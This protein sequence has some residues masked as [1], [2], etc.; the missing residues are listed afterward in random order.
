ME[1]LFSTTPTQKLYQLSTHADPNITS[2]SNKIT[3][4]GINPNKVLTKNLQPNL[5]SSKK[6]NFEGIPGGPTHN[7]PIKTFIMR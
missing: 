4:P 5:E 1:K 2:V 3:T 6:I 7:V